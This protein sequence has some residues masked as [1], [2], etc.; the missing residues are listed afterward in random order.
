MISRTFEISYSVGTKHEG[1][2]AINIIQEQ[3]VKKTVKG[4]WTL[5]DRALPLKFAG[6]SLGL[7]IIEIYESISTSTQFLKI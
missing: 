1:G 3:D 6:K 5:S 7:I 4:Y 2:V